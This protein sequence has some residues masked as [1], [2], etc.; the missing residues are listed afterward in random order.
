MWA[1]L[2]EDVALWGGSIDNSVGGS[3]MARQGV[4]LQTYSGCLFS[5]ITYTIKWFV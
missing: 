1:G 4:S 2:A 5:P 3:E